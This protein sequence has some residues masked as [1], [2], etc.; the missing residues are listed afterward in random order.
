MRAHR[1][2]TLALALAATLATSLPAAAGG[3]PD[4]DDLRLVGNPDDPV[5]RGML[6][7]YN[8][9]SWLGVC[10]TGFGSTE[11]GV[12][13]G[14]LGYSGGATTSDSVTW[15]SEAFL[16]DDVDC[17]GTESQL[18][19]CDHHIHTL[20][21]PVECTL[22]N[23]VTLACTAPDPTP[24]VVIPAAATNVSVGDP[25]ATSLSITWTL[26]TQAANVDLDPIEVQEWKL[27]PGWPREHEWTTIATVARTVTEHTAT[28][29]GA[30][31]TH[32]FRVRLIDNGGGKA[33]STSASAGTLPDKPTR[34][35]A[36]AD[37]ARA[38]LV[39]Q[40]PFYTGGHSVTGY[41]YRASSNGGTSWWRDWTDI[42]GTAKGASLSAFIAGLT[43]D[44][45]YTIELRSKTSSGPGLARET[46]VT[47]SASANATL[48]SA[49]DLRGQAHPTRARIELTWRP[50]STLGT[51]AYEHTEYRVSTDAGE[52]WDPA[53]TEIAW[54]SRHTT[55][56][57]YLQ[58]L[59]FETTYTIEMRVVTD[60][61]NGAT[62]TLTVT[63]AD[64]PEQ[65]G[66]PALSAA[67][68]A[69]DPAVTLTWTHPESLGDGTHEH[70]EYRVSADGGTTW[71]PDWTEAAEDADDT[72][73][74][75]ALTA[76][77]HATDYTFEMRLVTT[78]GNGEAA[79]ATATTAAAATGT[80]AGAPTVT[81]HAHDSVALIVLRWQRPES[82]GTGTYVR[83]EYRSSDDDG[84]TWSADWTEAT[85]SEGKTS[86]GVAIMG[87]KHATTY[88]FEMRIVTTAGNGAAGTAEATTPNAP[89]GTLA[90]APDLRGMAHDTEPK[91][92][93]T[94]RPPANLGTG[95]RERTEYRMSAD[96]GTTWA[97]DWTEAPETAASKT[98]SMLIENLALATTY[99]FEMRIVTTMGA[100]ETALHVVQTARPP[101]AVASLTLTAGDASIT[102]AWGAPS[103]DG[104]S[105]LSGYEHQL[106]NTATD[107]LVHDWTS[108][109]ADTETVALTGLT[110]GTMYTVRVRAVSAVGPG[111]ATEGQS[112][113]Q[114]PEADCTGSAPE[115]ALWAAC[116][117]IADIGNG[118]YG[119]L[120]E[121]GGTLS[122]RSFDYEGVSHIVEGIGQD[123]GSS[124][125]GEEGWI[126]FGSRTW[127]S[128]QDWVFEIDGDR[129]NFADAEYLGF[130]WYYS[131]AGNTIGWDTTD[132]GRSVWAS[133]HEKIEPLVAY[134]SGS[135]QNP[136]DTSWR[137]AGDGCRVDVS[138]SFDDADGND[139]TV[140]TLT[141][142]N[143]TVEGGR[144]GTP[145][146]IAN[147]TM[148]FVPAWSTAGSTG[149]LRVHLP[150]TERWHRAEQAFRVTSDSECEVAEVGSLAALT[151]EGGTMTPAFEPEGESYTVEAPRGAEQITLTV[152]GA[153]ST[154]AVAIDPSDADGVAEGHQVALGDAPVDITLTVTPEEGEGTTYTVRAE[155]AAPPPDPDATRAG[156]VALGEQSP[157]RG[158]QFFRN[159]S[160]DRASGDAVDYYTF[161]T[162]D[163]YNAGIG[164]RGQSIELA[165]T[166]EDANGRTIGTA[167]PPRD[168]NKDQV[169]IE[170][171]STPLDRGRY[172]LRVEALEDGATGYY[173]R[174]G[175]S[176][177]STSG[178]DS[179]SLRAGA[180][181][182]GTQ[183]PARGRQFL[184]GRSLHAD[185]GDGVDYYVFD[186]TGRYSLGLGARGQTI[187]LKVT[188]ENADGETIGTAGPPANP[189]KD[190]VYIEWLKQTIAQGTYYIRVE[191]LEAAETDYYL[192]YKFEDAPVTVSVADAEVHEGPGAT[193]DFEVSLDAPAETALDVSY[194]TADGTATAGSDYTAASGTVT[195]AVNEQTKTVSVAVLEDD[196][197]ESAETMT[198]TVSG[199][200]DVRI[201]RAQATGTITNSDPIPKAWLARFGRTVTG[202]VLDAVQGRL[203]APRRAGTRAQLAGTTL[204]GDDA[205]AAQRAPRARGWAEPFEH[206]RGGP[207]PEARTIGLAEAL[208]GSSF[209]LT[210]AGGT[211]GS[212]AV[213]GEGAV[214]QFDGREGAL[215]LDGEVT[216][217]LLGADW[218]A[219]R[220]RAGVALG[221]SRGSGGYR[222]SGACGEGSCAGEIEA[223]LT[224]LYPYAGLDVTRYTTLWAAG[225]HGAGE[226][227]V[228]PD[229]AGA[230]SADLKMTMGAV[231]VRSE[232][233][234]SAPGEGFELAAKGEGRMTRTASDDT[235][236]ANGRLAATRA[237]VWLARA[238][239]ESQR[240]F[241]LAS[242]ANI[243]PS[244][245]LGARLDGGDAEEGLGAEAGGGLAFND[246]HSGVTF[247]A[248]T[249]ALVAHEDDA[250][251]E[252][253]ASI[254]FGWD[255]GA[256]GAR[257]PA[258]SLE[259]GWGADTGTGVDALLAHDV[260]RSGEGAE[261]RET[262]R[263]GAKLGY[264]VAAFGGW[265]T[266]V[267]HAGLSL[268]PNARE[269]ALGWRL[270]PAGTKDRFSLELETRQRIPNGPEQA[271][272][273]SVRLQGVLR[274]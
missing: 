62:A 213:W 175:L 35:K 241:T 222:R 12:A 63:T 5:H 31:E 273:R 190:Q 23:A 145:Q 123:D 143:L 231:G 138:F 168:P 139:A 270:L 130:A 150:A 260:L 259:S 55:S 116:L 204:A 240:V 127:P 111:E 238:G 87:L 30:G 99:T 129:H 13:C 38:R 199:A 54:A 15:D 42:T 81:A 268:S 136:T 220:W 98:Q 171:L 14:Q 274:W 132:V 94:W 44:T 165:V 185:G 153:Y 96:G 254:T 69:S 246:P 203:E 258:L 188:L 72:T 67:A 245:E 104:T 92:R 184:R 114:S 162:D 242:G 219:D 198:L 148:W 182:L 248:R 110:N 205:R 207:E 46:T 103:E 250:F 243:T 120:V 193:L 11:A 58:D 223:T 86:H 59:A 117:T 95:T 177:A 151:V 19:D 202:H 229:G 39:W 255:G 186:T 18:I 140:D 200:A 84:A 82:L 41:E 225:G 71:S 160:L 88:D 216:S 40:A 217:G 133:I 83:T 253:G 172:Y 197:D 249:R 161:T 147:G 266:A 154:D 1:L 272:E 164:V 24:G 146:A 125:R 2:R 142:E 239:L 221:H 166:V 60:A 75:L 131:W 66:A 173:I 232:L 251:R 187:E 37:N 267:P 50:P 32:R 74:T 263:I 8:S 271:S 244:F 25:T 48:A 64:E 210:G 26:P 17:V 163:Y 236:G 78:V 269:I 201:E 183:S 149:A 100:G 73:H 10:D 102:V 80:V 47:P 65:A 227:T 194:T 119:Y 261:H 97:P 115:G 76:L 3:S 224:G 85:E 52:T 180:H 264:G 6:Q 108:V 128:A 33:D 215:D 118:D 121:R 79:S 158:R 195:F 237:D 112:S 34:L 77:S 28:E 141:S 106:V 189:N 57:M 169:Y 27:L 170:W 93:L 45:E 135:V 176:N 208:A 233:L 51:G 252:W 228:R 206:Q 101:A 61:G 212:A 156:A 4:D 91:I 192:R 265:A 235:T 90:D 49:P 124:G 209:A 70:T 107:A 191:A 16:L 157:G 113:P 178:L 226:V 174:F 152:Q 122:T 89:A 144:A 257:G 105:D 181:S 22:A 56:W 167:G 7:I 155:R 137:E 9:G 134:A 109:G 234:A 196:V 247:N 29:L 218:G 68:D 126:S 211:S 53:W 43:N 159:K 214:T 179:D 20:G 36:V 230:Q 21:N 256:R 262:G